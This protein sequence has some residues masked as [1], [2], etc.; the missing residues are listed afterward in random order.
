[1]NTFPST[2]IL[3]AAALVMVVGMANQA[4]AE[5]AGAMAPPSAGMEIKSLSIPYAAVELGTDDGRADLYGKIRQAARK[6]CGPTGLR[7]TGSLSISSRNRK[8]YQDAVAAAV[9]QVGS[10][11]LAAIGR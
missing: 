8:C 3:H 11:Q 5:Q 1:M 4:S 6:V 7:E 2:R 9:S 10:D